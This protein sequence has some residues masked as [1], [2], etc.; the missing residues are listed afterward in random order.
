LRLRSLAGR[1]TIPAYDTIETLVL[2]DGST[3]RTAAVARWRK[4]S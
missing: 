3:D 4:P 1:K 2:D